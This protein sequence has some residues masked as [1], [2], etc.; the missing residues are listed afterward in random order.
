MVLIGL[1]GGIG[2]GKSTVGQILVELGTIYIDA[3]KIGH[4]VYLP[5]TPGWNMV[6]SAFG[7]NILG[8]DRE[9][10][11]KKLAAMVFSDKQRLDK[12]N[13]IVHPL[14]REQIETMARHAE[15]NGAVVVVVEGAVLLE[16]G[17]SDLFDEVWM[18]AASEGDVVQRVKVSKGATE[19][20]TTARIRS[21]MSNEERKRH[22][23]VVIENSGTL[24]ELTEKVKSEWLAL[25]QR[26]RDMIGR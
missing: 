3:D 2:S 22:A 11:R 6:I 24:A 17:W 21:Q 9:V 20:E 25:N 10:D 19:E 4:E 7:E 1:T 14:I 15:E 5:G 12:L 18:V 16:A 23:L 13:K 26:H 8:P